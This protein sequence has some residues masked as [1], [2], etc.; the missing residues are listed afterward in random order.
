M[1]FD[2][3]SFNAI[4]VQGAPSSSGPWHPNASMSTVSTLQGTDRGVFLTLAANGGSSKDCQ[5]VGRFLSANINSS[6]SVYT[7]FT[8]TVDSTFTY[9]APR[10]GNVFIQVYAGGG[11]GNSTAP[12]SG[13]GRPGGGG[14]FSNKTITVTNGQEI[15]VTFSNTNWK[16]TVNTISAGYGGNSSTGSLGGLGVASGGDVNANGSQGA[17]AAHP[18][19]GTVGFCGYPGPVK[20]GYGWSSSLQVYGNRLNSGRFNTFGTGGFP[21][22]NLTGGTNSPAA[23]MVYIGIK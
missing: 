15:P 10:A 3:K 17:T 1:S 18:N 23:P 6:V 2:S 13:T 12:A 16:V 14:A 9:T 22:W 19:L 21:P 7:T 11:Y 4:E 8:P 5:I 20:S